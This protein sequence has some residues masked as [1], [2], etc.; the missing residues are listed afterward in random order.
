LKNNLIDHMV[1]MFCDLFNKS[2]I[3]LRVSTYLNHVRDQYRVQLKK[4]PKYDHP[5]A[6][7]E[8]EWKNIYEDAE[9]A[10]RNK[11]KI[12]PGPRR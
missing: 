9:N 11:G 4:K 6:I 12:P 2:E 1:G 10:F 3:T 7:P 5:L 8:R